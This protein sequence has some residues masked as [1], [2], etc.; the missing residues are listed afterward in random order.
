[1][2]SVEQ[3]RNKAALEREKAEIA[4]R[5]ANANIALSRA[6]RDQAE[7]QKADEN[8]KSDPLGDFLGA[9]FVII[10]ILGVI[11]YFSGK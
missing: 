8:S 1:M 2:A 10:F 5:L 11:G 9:V 4:G 6:K 3:L 7:A